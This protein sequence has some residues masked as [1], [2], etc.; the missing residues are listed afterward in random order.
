MGATAIIGGLVLG[1][2][3]LQQRR[4]ER[5]LKK[6]SQQTPQPPRLMSQGEQSERSTQARTD[7]R[8]TAAAATGRSD[9][10]LTSPLGLPG[11][12]PGTK[13]TLLGR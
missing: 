11:E 12:T 4:Q 3:I 9:T 10:I 5:A 1:G 8:Q 7:Q 13:K 6:A 2:S